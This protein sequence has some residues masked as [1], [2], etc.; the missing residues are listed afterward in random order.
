M[1]IQSKASAFRGEP[2][3][4]WR[5]QPICGKRLPSRGARGEQT[6]KGE[7]FRG[8]VQSGG[9]VRTKKPFRWK[10]SLFLGRKRYSIGGISVACQIEPAPILVR[11]EIV[12]RGTFP[13]LGLLSKMFH[14]EHRAF[15]I[16]CTLMRGCL[17]HNFD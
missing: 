5:T 10:T 16:S 8:K 12:P 14:V 9:S 11:V 15:Q 13:A 6:Y 4:L 2:S 7:G 1:A 3:E 17:R